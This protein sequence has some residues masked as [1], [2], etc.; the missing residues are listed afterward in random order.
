MIK[1]TTACLVSLVCLALPPAANALEF[2]RTARSGEVTVMGRYANWASDCQPR[3]GIVRPLMK[4]AHGTLSTNQEP[5][6]ASFNRFD[7][8]DPCLGR[9][10]KHF[11]IKYRSR[12]GFRGED[13]F[14]VLPI[15]GGSRNLQAIDTYSVHVR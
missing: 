11:V 14:S 5:H 9:T 13:S 10:I 15:W 1:T 7:P 12:P 2:T 8:S 6:I 3:V 4:P